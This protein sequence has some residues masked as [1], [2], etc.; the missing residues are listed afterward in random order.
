LDP[1]VEEAAIEPLIVRAWQL[2][3]DLTIDDGLFMA[4]AASLMTS[5]LRLARAARAHARVAVVT[6]LDA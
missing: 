5:D 2:R 1:G 3:D 6:H 4:L